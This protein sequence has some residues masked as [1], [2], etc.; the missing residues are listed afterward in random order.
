MATAPTSGR[1]STSSTS[2]WRLAR[3]PTHSALPGRIG[4][5]RSTDGTYWRRKTSDGSASA[6]A[7]DVFRGAGAEII[8][9]DLGTVPDFVR[10]SLA[11]SGVPGFRVLRWERCWHTPG[12]PFRDP[13]Q[14]P[15]ASVA[16]SGTH[17]TEPQV[18]WWEH[19]SADEREK[20]IHL[21]TVQQA[22]RGADL[23]QAP[24]N[25][26][27][28]DALLEALFASNSDLLLVPIQDAFGWRDRINEPATIADHNWTYKLPWPVDRLD[29][30]PEARERKDQMRAWSERYGRAG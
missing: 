25:P 23:H 13:S 28:R 11:R 30:I 6:R 1:A 16:S 21:P 4:A 24:Y 27:V 18:E 15:R 17:D 3:R 8:A 9:E 22:A 19:A 5:C 20:V 26:A 10:E 29:E 12:Q 7:L 14:Y 2:T